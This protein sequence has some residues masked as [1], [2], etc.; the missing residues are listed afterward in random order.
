MKI[1][2]LIIGGICFYLC[3]ATAVGKFL[4]GDYKTKPPKRIP[5]DRFPDIDD[6]EVS[7]E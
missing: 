6:V 7:D 5:K 4:S 2:I 1:A 3:L